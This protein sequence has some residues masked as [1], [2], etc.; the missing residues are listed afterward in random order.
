LVLAADLSE[1]R[2]QL[3]L[4]GLRQHGSAILLPF[5]TP[6]HDLI[7]IKIDILYAQ[8]ERLLPSEPGPVKHRDDEARHA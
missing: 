1:V 5:S 4:Y 7:A 2:S 6:D 3:G 8:L